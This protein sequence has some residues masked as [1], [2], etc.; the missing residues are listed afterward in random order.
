[1]TDAYR[2]RARRAAAGRDLEPDPALAVRVADLRLP[3]PDRR[4]CPSLVAAPGARDRPE[5]APDPRRDNIPNAPNPPGTRSTRTSPEAA[6]SS[7]TSTT[8]SGAPRRPSHVLVL[9]VSDDGTRITLA[10]TTT[11][12]RRLARLRRADHV[13]AA[14]LPAPASG[15][16]RRRAARSGS[17][18]RARSAIRLHPA[19][20]RDRELVHGRPAR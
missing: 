2:G 16:S 12:S 1:M 10:G 11:T 14:G 17:S 9:Q 18:T 19:G 6:T 15:R 3:R 4:V 20:R 7:S 8:A 13:G 5:D